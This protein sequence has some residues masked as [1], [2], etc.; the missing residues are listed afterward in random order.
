MCDAQMTSNP[1]QGRQPKGARG[2]ESRKCLILTPTR[3]DG[4]VYM[5]SYLLQDRPGSLT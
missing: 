4:T 2:P 5:D 1:R 3:V